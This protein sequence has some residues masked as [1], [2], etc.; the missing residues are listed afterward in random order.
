MATFMDLTLFSHFSIVFVFLLVFVIIYGFLMASNLFRGAEGSKGIY[1][2]IALAAAFLITL[3]KD[4]FTIITKITP[5]FT[6]LIIFLFLIFV[7]LKMFVG[8]DDTIIGG[9]IKDPSIYWVLLI[10]F[11]L[12]IVIALASTFGQRSLNSVVN[13]TGVQNN[14]VVYYQ[15]TGQNII[16]ANN[17]QA[18]VQNSPTTLDS[19]GQPTSTATTDY[20]TN[21]TNTLV[22]PKVLGMIAL[23]LISFFAIIFIAKSSNP[24]TVN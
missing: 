2:I 24:G 9:L 6:V 11:I 13:E 15:P 17:E 16:V 19:A 14:T 5:W 23:L 4:A 8:S 7:V 22:N 1:A 10:I 3:S 20:G 21:M 18:Y 12:I